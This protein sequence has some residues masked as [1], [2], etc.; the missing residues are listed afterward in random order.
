ML[1]GTEQKKIFVMCVGVQVKRETRLKKK[2]LSMTYGGG[3]RHLNSLFC[4]LKYFKIDNES[5]SK[6]GLKS[7]SFLAVR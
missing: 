6:A 3:E 4:L 1:E 5:F 2:R 7:I